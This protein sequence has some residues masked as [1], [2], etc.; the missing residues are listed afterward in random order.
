MD[1]GDE[2]K[3]TTRALRIEPTGYKLSPNLSACKLP[4]KMSAVIGGAH[5]I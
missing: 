2:I 4:L 1:T 5:K 3:S